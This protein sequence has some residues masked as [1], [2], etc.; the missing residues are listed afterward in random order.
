MRSIATCLSLLLLF[1]VPA[2]AAPAGPYKVEIHTKPAVIPVG[3]ADILVKVSDAKGPVSGAT[4]RVL[5][6]MPNMPMGEREETAWPV[7]GSPGLYSAPARFGMEGAYEVAVTVRGPL[8]E[9]RAVIPVLTGS[10]PG[11]WS[12][13]W[14]WIAAV[15]VLAALVFAARRSRQ[16]LLAVGLL[17]VALAGAVWSVQHLRRPGAMTP[18]QAQ[19]MEMDVPAP[20]GAVPV[21]LGGVDRGTVENVVTYSGQAVG[22]DEQDVSPRVQ[23]VI[24][25]MPVYVGTRVTAGQVVARLDTSQ[26]GPQVAEKRAAVAV[27]EL[28]SQAAAAETEQARGQMRQA[29]SEVGMKAGEIDEAR[30]GLEAART[31]VEDAD[32]QLK[33]ALAEQA[34]WR[35]ERARS[36]QLLAA[37][38]YSTE[39]YQKDV[40][41]AEAADAKVRQAQARVR[42]VQ[43]QIAAA[44]ASVRKAESDLH[45]HHA[46]E[47]QAAAAL[48]ASEA[49]ARAADA[50]VRQARASLEMTAAQEGYAQI[51]ATT[52][53]V[54][55]QRLISPGTLVSP[56]QAIL[57]IARTRPI[58]LQA[59]VAS[60]DLA[61]VKVGTEVRV[62]PQDAKQRA[63]RGRVTSVQPAVDPVAR[64][65]VVEYVYPNA[66]DR[67]VPG[68]FLTMA[69]ATE[70]AE[71][72]LRVPSGA[73]RERPLPQAAPDAVPL[74]FF[75]WVA[76]PVEGRRYKVHAVPAERLADD[77]RR[78]AVRA[79]LAPG[80]RVVV[81]GGEYLKD[82]DEVVDVAPSQPA[83]PAGMSGAASNSAVIE[84]TAKGFEPSTLAVRKGV[85]VRITF[86]RKTEQTCATSVVFP[87]FGI[88]RRLPLKE[89]VVVEFTP[90]TSGT[91]AFT[92]GMKMLRGTVISQ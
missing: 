5:A 56:G 77:G 92:C 22:W 1:I 3:T 29:E 46:H 34:Y 30:A 20:P 15:L 59:N 70:R 53:G 43:A 62:W 14:A 72:A 60:S 28:Q 50:A 4:V 73:L 81:G 61:R 45:S 24:L 63:V 10:S 37:G 54:V 71:N 40:S 67:F 64:T 27:V 86:V 51:R 6:Q 85:P 23:G 84:V 8:G 76:E 19:S 65:G 91:V 74:R 75:V 49:K 58:R 2:M 38:A 39:E 68:G 18:I 16:A 11:G 31:Q 79:D 36:Q 12:I 35:R 55:T 66:D 57:R 13:P 82:A 48:R 26:L 7:N 44:E 25:E 90:E 41:Q 17:A 52:D 80:D 87:D 21:E 83:S 88:D 33:A 78:V 69:I 42:Q 9:G 32:A 47:T 89:P